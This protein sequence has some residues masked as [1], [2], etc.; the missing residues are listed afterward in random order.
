MIGAS[1]TLV[2]RLLSNLATCVSDF[3]KA[4]SKGKGYVTTCTCVTF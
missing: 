4:V 3:L 1:K 2:E